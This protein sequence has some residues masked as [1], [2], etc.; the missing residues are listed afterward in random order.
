MEKGEH[1]IGYTVVRSKL[2]ESNPLPPGTSTQIVELIALTRTSELE[3]DRRV[4]IYT[5]PKYAYLV[6]H[7]A[8]WKERNFK[9]T[10][11]SPIKYY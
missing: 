2:L 3:T 11:G 4:S 7:T 10:D 8:I 6:L 1:K 9:T 5:H